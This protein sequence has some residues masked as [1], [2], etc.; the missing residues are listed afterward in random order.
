[1]RMILCKLKIWVVSNSLWKLEAFWWL[2][3]NRALWSPV[4]KVCFIAQFHAR[5]AFENGVSLPIHGHLL[6]VQTNCLCLLFYRIFY[7]NG[8][9][10]DI[11]SLPTVEAR[12]ADFAPGFPSS[13]FPHT[14]ILPS[15]WL[16]TYRRDIGTNVHIDLVRCHKW[17]DCKPASEG[18][19]QDLCAFFWFC[20]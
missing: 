18:K 8:L 11:D 1:M 12:H 7:P 9:P 20:I 17:P 3:I 13:L 10:K 5:A 4:V 14:P 19:F 2:Q 16:Q 6:F 15:I